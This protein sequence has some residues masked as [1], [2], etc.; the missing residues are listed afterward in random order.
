MTTGQR[1]GYFLNEWA[2]AIIGLCLLSA[3]LIFYAAK[4]DW[5]TPAWFVGVGIAFC[6]PFWLWKLYLIRRSVNRTSRMDAQQS[7]GDIQGLDNL[8]QA[9][10]LSAQPTPFTQPATYQASK[11]KRRGG[12]GVGW[13]IRLVAIAIAL[14]WGW[15]NS[16]QQNTVWDAAT[17][18]HM[19]IENRLEANLDVDRFSHPF[20]KPQ[21]LLDQ[22]KPICA[23]GDRWEVESQQLTNKLGLTLIPAF[24]AECTAEKT[25]CADTTDWLETGIKL[26]A[27]EEHGQTVV[28]GEENRTIMSQKAHRFNVDRRAML[29]AMAAN[30]AARGSTAR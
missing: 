14:Y 27:R 12:I 10:N 13:K 21:E 29:E 8:S 4:S 3:A 15:H 22:L 25:W 1:I 5:Q 7:L 9:S 6:V 18:A 17:K 23:E 19:E 20:A 2:V 16:R 24:I 30:D 28:F 26:E 11:P